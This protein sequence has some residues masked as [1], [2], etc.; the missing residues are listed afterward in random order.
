MQY[1][2]VRFT[3][4]DCKNNDISLY[5]LATRT[6]QSLPERKIVNVNFFKIKIVSSPLN[7][8]KEREAMM[9]DLLMKLL[10]V[11]NKSI[12]LPLQLK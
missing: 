6:K 9:H 7:I 5:L 1:W 12:K 10:F 8:S 11:K 3:W 2:G 4:F